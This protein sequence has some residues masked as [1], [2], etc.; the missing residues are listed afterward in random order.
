MEREIAGIWGPHAADATA[1]P[2]STAFGALLQ[3]SLNIFRAAKFC[4]AVE[5]KLFSDVDTTV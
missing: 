2:L 1:R 5:H 3:C 4:K